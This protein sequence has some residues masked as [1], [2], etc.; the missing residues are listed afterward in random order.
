M[1]EKPNKKNQKIDQINKLIKE[2]T[3]PIAEIFFFVEL[4]AKLTIPEINPR[5]ETERKT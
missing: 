3:I 4:N 2:R 5:M 1:C